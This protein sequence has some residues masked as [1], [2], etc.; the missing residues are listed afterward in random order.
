MRDRLRLRVRVRGGVRVGRSV[1]VRVRKLILFN[2][3]LYFGDNFFTSNK[4]GAYT[5]WP[6]YIDC[7][8]YN[9]INRFYGNRVVYESFHIRED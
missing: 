6:I 5:F 9:L 7:S 1:W 2:F 4:E 3:I 8:I